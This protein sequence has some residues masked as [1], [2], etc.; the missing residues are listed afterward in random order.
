MSDP[1]L[2]RESSGLRWRQ[3]GQP[4][5]LNPT[6]AWR[7]SEDATLTYE[8]DGMVAGREY[9]TRLEVW[10]AKA[11]ERGVKT[12]LT[13]RDVATGGTQLVRRDLSLSEIGAGE[14]RLLVKIRDT[15]SRAEATQSRTLVIKP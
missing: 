2:G 4:V 14:F 10:Q 11:P 7:R 5:P 1:I 12:V 15:T 6:G 13:F 8:V 9:E 3:S